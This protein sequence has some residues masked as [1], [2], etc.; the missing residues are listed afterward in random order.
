MEWGFSDG[1]VRFYSA[2]SRK[3][4]GH[5][6]HLHIG[7]MSAAIFADSKTL[8]T[9]GLDCTV[10]V[11]NLLV[12]GKSIELPLKACFFGHRKPVTVLALSRSFSALLSASTDGEVMLWDLNR[13]E[14]VRKLKAGMV[15]D[16]ARINDVTGNIVTCQGARI[17]MYTL[18]GELLLDQE[19]GGQDDNI[20]CC[21]FYEGAGNEWLERDILFTGHPNGVVK[22]WN[23]V[24]REGRFELELI[25]QLNHLDT[26]RDDGVNVGAGITCVLPMPQVVYTG[27]EDGKVVS[28]SSDPQ[29]QLC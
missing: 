15:V 8:I 17:K 28:H 18:N 12:N 2:D 24:I 3:L 6:E 9:S 13:L 11:W 1:S 21:A 20:L 7:Q 22:V 10:S 4:V 25:R 19:S 14:F 16:C 26:S 23:K 27:D 5:M 29:L